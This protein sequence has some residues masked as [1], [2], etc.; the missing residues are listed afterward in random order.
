MNHM[1]NSEFENSR[2]TI[3]SETE[4]GLIKEYG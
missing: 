4:K 3:Q 1:E 2:I